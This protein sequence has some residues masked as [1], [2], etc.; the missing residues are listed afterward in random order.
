[1]PA[2]SPSLQRLADGPA[3]WHRVDHHERTGSTNDLAL[4]SLREGTPPGHVITADH[5]T[6]GRGRRGRTWE[7]RGAGASLACSVTLPLFTDHRSLVPIVAG[8]AAG[9]A[10]RRQGV[11]AGLKWPNDV[12]VDVGDGSRRKLAGI[13]AEAIPEGIVVGIGLNLDLR[14]HDPV[15]G[16]ISVAELLDEPVDPWVLVQAYLRALESWLRDLDTVGPVRTL[17]TYRQRCVTIGER[18]V[19]TVEQGEV[20]GRVMDVSPQGALVVDTDG[21]ARVQVSSGEVLSVR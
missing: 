9:D 8:V 17:A 11:R 19:A 14:G 15:D 12:V 21:G 2:P 13:L 4:A 16:A 7:D 6:D 10:L 5:Q 20:T 1:M 3:Y 18:V